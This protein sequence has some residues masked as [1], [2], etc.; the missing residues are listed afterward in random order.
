MTE[1]ASKLKNSEIKVEFIENLPKD[2]IKE[3]GKQITVL[4]EKGESG[5]IEKAL[6]IKTPPGSKRV[7]K[8]FLV[9]IPII[10]GF[11]LNKKLTSGYVMTEIIFPNQSSKR[12]LMSLTSD[13]LE[14]QNGESVRFFNVSPIRDDPERYIR[15]EDRKPLITFFWDYPNP[16]PIRP[17]Q[18]EVFD[19]DTYGVLILRQ[20]AKAAAQPVKDFLD[21]VK[22]D[23]TLI[24]MASLLAAVGA[25]ISIAQILG[26]L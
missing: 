16:I 4:Q 13:Y 10:G 3:H 26:F 19:L 8:N 17:K 24:K 11:I 23:M 9:K 2:W 22:K 15:Y 1:K 5:K 12:Y 7:L 21:A 20:R 18:S 6:Y 14:V 25:V